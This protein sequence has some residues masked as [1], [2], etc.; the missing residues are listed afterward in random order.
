MKSKSQGD[1]ALPR[2]SLIWLL[3]A[4][5]T[6]VLPHIERLPNWVLGVLLVCGFWRVMIW[7]GRWSFPPSSLKFLLVIVAVTA[8]VLRFRPLLGLEALVAI[9]ITAFGLKL[10]EMRQQR[11]AFLVVML[12]Y[13]I[14]MTEFLFDQGIAMA[15]LMMLA[16]VVVTTALIGLQQTRGHQKPLRTFQ[17][18]GILVAQSLPVMLVLFVLFPRVA[19]LWSVQLNAEQAQSGMSDTMSPGDVARLGLSGA[20]AF[21][22]EFTGERPLRHQMYWRTLTFS[23]F[24]GRTWK[25]GFAEEKIDMD[26]IKAGPFAASTPAPDVLK[27]RLRYSVTMEPTNQPWLFALG[28]PKSRTAGVITMPDAR[29]LRTDMVREKFQYDVESWGYYRFEEPLDQRQFE[30]STRIPKQGNP[31]AKELALDLR[32]RM[33]NDEAFLDAVLARF[34]REQ[35]YYTLRPP[36]LGRD[37]VDEFLFESRRGFCEHYASSFVFL[38]RAAGIPARVVVGYQGGEWNEAGDYLM[39]HQFDA[40][41]WAEAWF[42]D[43]GWVRYDPTGAVAPERVEQGV[44][45]SRAAQSGEIGVL[46]PLRYRN[47]PVL[48][49]LRM[50][51]DRLDYYWSRFVLGYDSRTQMRALTN[52][53]GSMNWEKMV[54]LLLGF[55][56]SIYLFTAFMILSKRSS[57]PRDPVTRAYLA[58]CHKLARNG[59]AREPGEGP[60]DLAQRAEQRFPTAQREI[61]N[62]TAAYV[63]LLYASDQDPDARSPKDPAVRQ[64]RRMIRALSGLQAPPAPAQ[65]P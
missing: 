50:Q 24:D 11:D 8:I 34:Q 39:V 59:L 32:E 30:V 10:L 52:W 43:H 48:Q 36:L 41:A 40:H 47:I 5:V 17:L 53:F 18:A 58:F 37:S 49:W 12:S 42:P 29:L 2:N 46:D 22:V 65:S 25:R 56:G 27:D 1:Y 63:Q 61:R 26:R 62:I 14:I 9:L 44:N 13:F 19:P 3:A 31:R 64:L 33:G 20:P 23:F 6:V 57:R 54:M 15:L 21:R 45:F 16:F 4:Q 38:A 60:W 7:Q 28:W 51:S 35:F 55:V